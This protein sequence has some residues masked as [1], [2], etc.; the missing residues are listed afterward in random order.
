MLQSS[1]TN[2][3]S[4]EIIHRITVFSAIDYIGK[5]YHSPIYRSNFMRATFVINSDIVDKRS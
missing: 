5:F 4:M 3:S 1:K 2:F